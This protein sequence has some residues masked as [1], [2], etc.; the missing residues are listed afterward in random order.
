MILELSDGSSG[1][2]RGAAALVLS[3]HVTAGGVGILSGAAALF[4]RKGSRL[5]RIAGNWFFVAILTMAAIGA[6]VAPFLP[7]RISSVAGLLTFYL[8]LTSWVTIRRKDGR[9]GHFEIGALLLA[10]GLIAIGLILGTRAASSPTGMLDRE[11][12]QAAFAFTAVAA[13][14]AAGDLRLI[15]RGGISGAQRIV[16]HLWR[17]CVALFIAAASFFLGQPKVF[18]ASIRGSFILFMPEIAVLGLLI[19]WLIRVR[20]TNG[21]KVVATDQRAFAPGMGDDQLARPSILIRPSGRSSPWS[22]APPNRRVPWR[23]P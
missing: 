7:D 9:V 18:P 11:P 10:V 2:A 12:F 3:L 1:L 16:R 8:V 4:F 20:F 17:M 23:R 21:F 13:L 6:C 19:F 15:L 22:C 14:A 5:H